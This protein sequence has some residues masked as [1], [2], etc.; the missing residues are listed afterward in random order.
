MDGGN[1][2]TDDWSG[3]LGNSPV[4]GGTTELVAYMFWEA[5]TASSHVLAA[6]VCGS[7]PV[8]FCLHALHPDTLE[9]LAQWSA[10]NRTAYS[11]YW[12]VVDG[13]VTIPTAQGYLV[14]VDAVKSDDG[15]LS[16]DQVQEYDVS[17]S[18]AQGSILATVGFGGDGNLWFTATAAP[19]L[20]LPGA[21][22]SSI[23]YIGT[24]GALHA[25][26]LENEL[27]ENGVAINDYTLYVVTGPAGTEDHANAVGHFYAFQADSSGGIKAAY[28]ETYDAGSAIKS[29][30]LSRGSGSSVS[31]IGHKYVGIT[32]NAD[33][34]INL[35]VY[36]QVEALD[37]AGGSAL[38]CSF[39]LFKLNASANEASLT[40]FF[41]GSKYSATINNAYG[42]P[43]TMS[44]DDSINGPHN[45]MTVMAPG[46]QRIDITE[47]GACSLAWEL[48]VRATMTTLSTGTGLFYAY[49]QDETLA[50]EGEYAWYVVAYDWRTGEEVWRANMGNG[51]VYNTGVSHIQLGP[52]GR[53]YE[54]I[55]GGMSWM[56]DS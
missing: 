30:G 55:S 23:G 11:N 41:D 37:E 17:T 49:T 52:N 24:N 8:N 18:M 26:T 54:G 25:I 21:P 38:A 27:I 33:E 22:A 46:T 48:D 4:V 34:Q 56:Q 13:R 47:D 29:G 5:A 12:Q 35:L 44:S 20:G 9:S 43:W 31:L 6:V 32:D 28:N 53:I 50:D 42:S 51:G 3:P 39:P 2:R 45:N 16:F 40:T 1:T 7:D 14:V 15:A 10:P 19:I 36:R